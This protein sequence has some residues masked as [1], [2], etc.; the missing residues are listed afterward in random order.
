MRILSTSIIKAAIATAVVG[1]ASTCAS[2]AQFRIDLPVQAQWGQTLLSPGKYT[3]TT[4]EGS[5]AMHIS[6][7]GKNVSVLAAA[8]T[9]LAHD[10]QSRLT[11]V[12]VNGTRVVRELTLADMGRDYTFLLPSPKSVNSAATRTL[13][14]TLRDKPAAH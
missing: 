14:F 13:A 4:N 11:M 5:P 9:Q 6:G 7:N 1:V 12:N 3:V 10:S 8:T 2:A